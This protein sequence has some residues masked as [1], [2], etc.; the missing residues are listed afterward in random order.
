MST[1]QQQNS[2]QTSCRV[3]RIAKRL[4]SHRKI[5]LPNAG[6]ANSIPEWQFEMLDETG[7]SF[8]NQL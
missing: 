7:N 1:A 5:R 3:A 8:K 4:P 6:D 2:R